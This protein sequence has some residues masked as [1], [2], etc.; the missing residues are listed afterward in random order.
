MLGSGWFSLYIEA[1][2]NKRFSFQAL[3]YNITRHNVSS[4]LKFT[5]KMRGMAFVTLSKLSHDWFAVVIWGLRKTATTTTVPNLYQQLHS[6]GGKD[7]GE[8]SVGL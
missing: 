2:F 6:N 1:A 3:S 5:Y 4:T 7:E 8:N